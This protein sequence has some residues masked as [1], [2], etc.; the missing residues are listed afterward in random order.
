MCFTNSFYPAKNKN[1]KGMHLRHLSLSVI[2]TLH[3]KC[4]FAHLRLNGPKGAL[5]GRFRPAE[6]KQV[7]T[8]LFVGHELSAPLVSIMTNKYGIDLG[9]AGAVLISNQSAAMFPEDV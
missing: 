1:M 9:C 6:L 8:K 7:V 3:F 5:N 2:F 4:R